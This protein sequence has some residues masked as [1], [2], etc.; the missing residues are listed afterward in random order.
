MVI[1]AL[2]A[3]SALMMLGMGLPEGTQRSVVVLTPLI[4][5]IISAG[6]GAWLLNRS[7]IRTGLEQQGVSH[8]G[9]T[10]RRAMQ[11]LGMFF[12]IEGVSELAKTGLDSYFVGA[13]WQIRASNVVSGLVN[14]S[15]GALLVLIPATI[16]EKLDR[17][18]R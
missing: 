16:A 13:D 2:T 5:G 7:A 14:A 4:Q 9:A 12:L 1:D 10:F 6:A 15:A 18:R 11:L 3:T 8:A 17:V